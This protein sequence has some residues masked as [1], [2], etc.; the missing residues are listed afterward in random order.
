MSPIAALRTRDGVN[1]ALRNLI[2]AMPGGYCFLKPE[3]EELKMGF[4]MCVDAI[5]NYQHLQLHFCA[6]SSAI[7]LAWIKGERLRERICKFNNDRTVV[8]LWGIDATKLWF[9]LK[10]LPPPH[11]NQPL[12]WATR[13]KLPH[14]SAASRPGSLD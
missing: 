1:T 3:T 10:L 14:W 6:A 2:I 8:F 13:R 9:L 4:M 11:I 7:L 5:E 12:D